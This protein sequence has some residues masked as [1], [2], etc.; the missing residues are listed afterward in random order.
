[1][2][3]RSYQGDLNAD[4]LADFLVKLF[5]PQKDLQ[6]QRI[7][8]Q[9]TYL[10]QI[11]RGDVPEDLRHAVT[12][13]ITPTEG[14][15]KVAMGQQNW[16]TPQNATFTV[17]MGLVGLLVTP[18]ALFALLWPLSDAVGS[19]TMPSDIW[20]AIDTYVVGKGGSTTFTEELRHP[21]APL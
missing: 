19:T 6:A 1:M 11:G 10:V 7:G 18:F 8:E 5:D 16:L 15:I 9:G 2:E 12:V 3:Q 21:H 13:A 14:G 20:E 17:A 4:E